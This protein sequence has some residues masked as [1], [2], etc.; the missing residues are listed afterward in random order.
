VRRLNGFEKVREVLL[1]EEDRETEEPKQ[2]F[3]ADEV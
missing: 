1:L 2:Q 3:E